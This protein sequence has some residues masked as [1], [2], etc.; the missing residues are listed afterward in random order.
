MKIEKIKIFEKILLGFLILV[1]M[2]SLFFYGLVDALINTSMWGTVCLFIWVIVKIFIHFKK[3][4][5]F[6]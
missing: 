1:F 3:N 2:G 4:S 6:Y 5:I